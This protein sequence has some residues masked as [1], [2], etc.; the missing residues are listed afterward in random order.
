MCDI[1]HDPVDEE[2]MLDGS[3]IHPL[4]RELIARGMIVLGLVF[5]LDAIAIPFRP[6]SII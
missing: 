3:V 4:I 6:V 1:Q 2:C 5:G